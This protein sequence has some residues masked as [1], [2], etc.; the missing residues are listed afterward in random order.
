MTVHTR[1]PVSRLILL[2]ILMLPASLPSILL[3]GLM[4]QIIRL[5]G[6]RV[7]WDESVIFRGEKLP[8]SFSSDKCTTHI[9]CA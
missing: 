3:Y 2:S 1:P 9:R 5:T 8:F 6:A 4:I 7:A